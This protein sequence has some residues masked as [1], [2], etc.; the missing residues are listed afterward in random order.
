LVAQELVDL[1]V[2]GYEAWNRG[3]R[4]WVLDHM[5]EDFEWH[6]PPDDPDPGIYRGHEGVV[7]FWDRWGEVFGQL[8]FEVEEVLDPDN[9]V[10]VGAKRLGT[11]NVSGVKIEERV[12]QVFTF[13]GMKAWRCGEFYDRETALRFAGVAEREETAGG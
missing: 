10:I 8:E 7:R 12:Y 4:Q 1:V 5:H 13:R 6:T 3:D 9:H 2:Q 11:G